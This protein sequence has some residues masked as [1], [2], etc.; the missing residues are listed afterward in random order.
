MIC[1]IEHVQDTHETNVASFTRTN[2]ERQQGLDAG[3]K[4]N[5]DIRALDTIPP[6]YN[7]RGMAWG[8]EPEEYDEP[9]TRPAQSARVLGRIFA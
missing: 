2:P 6:D 1:C 4:N 3:A 9:L 8:G 7:W 5:T